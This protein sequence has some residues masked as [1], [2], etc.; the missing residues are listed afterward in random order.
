VLGW[1]ASLFW[2]FQLAPQ[3]YKNARE[4]SCEG[5]SILM[6]IAWYMSGCLSTPYAILVDLILPLR[7][8]PQFFA[9]F[10]GVCVV[11]CLHYQWKTHWL[12]LSSIVVVNIIVASGVEA[13]LILG[14]RVMTQ[15][16]IQWILDVLGILPSVLI[17]IGYIPQYYDILKTRNAEGISILFM[18]IDITGGLLSAVS[19]IYHEVVD[20]FAMSMYLAVVI[21]DFGIIL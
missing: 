7:I 14:L 8:Q 17:V 9:F 3:V 15:N 6:M 21:L 20:W 18:S 1:I 4:K 11:Q 19:L 13:G 12:K 16:P 2:A 5:L 10:A